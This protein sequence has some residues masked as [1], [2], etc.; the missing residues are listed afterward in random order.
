MY[1]S[2]STSRAGGF[3]KWS[4]DHPASNDDDDNSGGATPIAI[5]KPPFDRPAV[6]ELPHRPWVIPGVGGSF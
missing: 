2:L 4:N 5:K 1:I 6:N 3:K